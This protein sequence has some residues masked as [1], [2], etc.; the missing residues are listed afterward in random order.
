[1][2]TPSPAQH[3]THAIISSGPSRPQPSWRVHPPCKFEHRVYRVDELYACGL[4]A[5]LT[6]PAAEELC[7]S[8][9]T[10]AAAFEAYPVLEEA[11]NAGWAAWE[12]ESLRRAELALAKS[13]EGFTEEVERVSVHKG[14]MTRYEERVSYPPNPTS[15]TFKL[16]RRD[17]EKYGKDVRAEAPSV[18]QQALERVSLYLLEKGL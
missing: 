16:E 15:L 14:L 7:V 4:R 10:L 11:Y 17:R 2:D 12:K 9:V 6:E 8:A 1:M 3:A 5:L 18:G 13:A